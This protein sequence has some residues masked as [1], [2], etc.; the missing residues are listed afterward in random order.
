MRAFFAPA[1][2]G[3]EGLEGRKLKLP[4]DKV[5]N[6]YSSNPWFNRGGGYSGSTYTGIFYYS[7]YYGGV[8]ADNTFRPV[9]TPI[10]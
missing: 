5:V 4:R 3:I 8:G 7:Y 2:L 6:G 1:L 9:V 10:S